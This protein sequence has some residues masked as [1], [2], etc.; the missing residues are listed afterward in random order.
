MPR[1]TYTTKEEKEQALESKRKT[2]IE[3]TKQVVTKPRYG[4]F[5][6][7]A[8]LAIGENSADTKKKPRRDEDGNVLTGPR[9]FLTTGTKKGKG[10]DGLFSEVGYLALGDPYIEQ[11]KIKRKQEREKNSKNPHDVAFKPGGALKN[12]RGSNLHESPYPHMGGDKTTKKMYKD[13]EG[14]VITGPKNFLT[15]GKGKS[16]WDYPEY[17]SDDYDNK[18]KLELAQ[19]RREA[20]KF[21]EKPFKS[22]TITKGQFADNIHTFGEDEK[23]PKT[24]KTLKEPLINKIDHD[25]PFRPSNPGKSGKVQTFSSFPKY[26]P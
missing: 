26:Y 4:L 15:S 8:P 22:M 24:R 11:A 14:G 3:E 10:R 21:Q 18:R 20:E 6:Q 2:L 25:K 5:S 9:N 13:P 23:V 19:K 7:P 16:F 17:L 1:E 12:I